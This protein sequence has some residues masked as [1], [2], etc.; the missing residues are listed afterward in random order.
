MKNSFLFSK[1][2]LGLVLISISLVG[3]KVNGSLLFVAL[4]LLGLIK[5]L[6]ALIYVLTGK[7]PFG[8]YRNVIFILF[9]GAVVGFIVFDLPSIYLFKIWVYQADI[10][11]PFSNFL[12]YSVQALGWGVF[13]IVFYDS[14]KLIHLTLDRNFH[15]IGPVSHYKTLSEKT[16]SFLGFLGVFIFLFS[17]A[18]AITGLRYTWWPPT[19]AALGTWFILENIEFRKNG[20]TLL[21]STSKGH[22]APLLSIFIGSIGLGLIFEYFNIISPKQH[23]IYYGLPFQNLHIA[24][25]PLFLLF[26][27][28]WMYIIFLSIYGIIYKKDNLWK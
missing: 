24:G 7:V 17:I 3:W 22:I 4:L 5:F 8:N 10:P 9:L 26:S 20:K 25:V 15:T 12:I 16:F 19:L 21:F 13:L 27:W 14:Y 11:N 1:I 6:G 23:W 2:S 28:V 18:L